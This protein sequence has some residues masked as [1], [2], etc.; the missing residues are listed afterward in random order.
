MTKYE[1]E[2]QD[3]IDKMN[4][5]L[6]RLEEN[7]EQLS[8]YIKKCKNQNNI[9]Q[10]LD[11]YNSVNKILKMVAL[12]FAISAVL[13]DMKEHPNELNDK[14]FVK[15]VTKKFNE[16]Q[17]IPDD[18]KTFSKTYLKDILTGK[19]NPVDIVTEKNK[20]ENSLVTK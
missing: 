19:L 17:Y 5:N 10:L 7:K 4:Q 11:T 1:K 13:F 12:S 3:Y 16:A 18:L 8:I 9:D 15:N 14:V 6:N 2:K 20:I